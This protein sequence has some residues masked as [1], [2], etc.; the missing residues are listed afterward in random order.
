MKI[1]VFAD[2]HYT[3]GCT[4][5]AQIL[6]TVLVEAERRGASFV[7]C[8][9]DMLGTGTYDEAEE[10]FAVFKK[11]KIPVAFSLGNAECRFFP[12]ASAAKKVLV[13]DPLPEGIALLDTSSCSCDPAEIASLSGRNLLLITHVPPPDWG[14]EAF[15]AWEKARADSVISLTVAG[16]MHVDSESPG[17]VIVRGLDPDKAQGGP[18]AVVFFDDE[19]GWHKSSVFEIP[20]IRPEEWDHAFANAFLEDLGLSAMYDPF[21]S[22]DFAISERVRNLELRNGTW[23]DEDFP[24]LLARV[25]EWRR[26]CGKC[27]SLH[28]PVL[29]YSN[30]EVQGVAELH[31][32]SLAAVAL[33]C[34]RVTLHIPSLHYSAAPGWYLALAGAYE[35]ALGPLMNTGIKIG[36][37]NMHMTTGDKDS[38]DRKY[39]YIPM[40]CNTFIGML[41]A[42]DEFDVG[43][44]LDIGHA[45]NNAPFDWSN[46]ISDWITYFGPRI[47]GMHIH[48]V[49]RSKDGKLENHRPLDSFFGSL[50]SLASIIYARRHGII[51]RAPLFIEVRDGLGPE[52]YL[53]LTRLCRKAARL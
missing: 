43:F 52:S 28:L 38:M 20:H 1:A 2:L 30:G 14:G 7:V 42:Y 17:L 32:A 12:K 37:E 48:Q 34:D 23:K 6:N 27:L 16:H 35:Q 5:K 10:L 29:S 25:A 40:E 45:R 31:A 3:S 50:I 51:P 8:A 15:Q 33:R 46:P 36:I 19:G 18:P 24:A 26:T 21:G 44:H 53:T 41:N 39:G 13:S 47:N 49:V 11:H 9:G 4:L 22:L